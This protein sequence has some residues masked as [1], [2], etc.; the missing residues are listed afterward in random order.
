MI[1]KD[2]EKNYLV[3]NSFLNYI[4]ATT[5]IRK[6]E[7]MNTLIEEVLKKHQVRL[8]EKKTKISKNFE[9]DLPEAIVPDEQLR[10]I[11]DTVL[12]YAMASMPSDANIEFLT[13]SFAL[14]KEG[15]EVSVFEKDRKYIEVLVAYT[16]Y[17]K[18]MERSM[19]E[20]I[21]LTSQEEIASDLVL[22][23]VEVIVKMN[24]GIMRF[25]VDETKVKKFIFLRFPAERRKVVFSEPINTHRLPNKHDVY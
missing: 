5:P 13:K 9:K 10:F 20:L 21:T 15:R 14:Q 17:K 16:S 2:I 8:E 22:K 24:Q 3:L 19:E 23:L 11:L 12:Q 4:K 18:P 25:E 7:T 1:T 6:K